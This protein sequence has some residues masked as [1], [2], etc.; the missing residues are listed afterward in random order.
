MLTIADI[1]RGLA[2]RR[3]LQLL[4]ALTALAIG[5]GVAP[6]PAPAA[7]N[8]ARAGADTSYGWP[9]KPFDRAHPIRGSFGDPRTLFHAP[10]TI[11]GLMHGGGSFSFHQGVD[12][13]AP[14][15][16]AVYPV[17]DGVVSTVTHEWIRVT[18]DGGRAFEYWHIHPAV[19][20]GA[21]VEAGKTLLGRILRESGHVHLT[22]L[23]NG[24]AVNPL[25]PGHLTPYADHT[26]PVVTAI[27]LRAAGSGPDLLANFVRGSLEFD[28][29]AYD[30]PE[31]PVPGAWK[32][33]PVTPALVTWRIEHPNGKVAVATTIAVDVRQTVPENTAFWSTYARGT[34]QN[35]AVFGNHYSYLQRGSYVFRLTPGGFDTR[36]LRD[37]VYDLVV[38]VS[39]I[40]GNTGSASVRFT[41]HN[42]P[43]WVGSGS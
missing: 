38:T 32:G 21:R 36:R 19:Y 30:T 27:S 22:E 20:A 9:V 37:G 7:E 41:V 42:K 17:L 29:A 15:G 16:T 2:P 34:F 11:D 24:R 31:L 18:S 4:V 1:S 5:G 43:G 40:A 12:I 14:D 28:A 23:L 13:S 35:M 33:L 8:A 39:D 25:R 26:R 10:P 6:A 3:A